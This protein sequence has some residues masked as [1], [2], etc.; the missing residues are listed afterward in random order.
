MRATQGTMKIPLARRFYDIRPSK[1]AWA[2][3]LGFAGVLFMCAAVSLVACVAVLPQS[4]RLPV[5]CSAVTLGVSG[6]VLCGMA[7]PVQRRPGDP[8]NTT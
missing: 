1:P 5:L 7:P 4:Q 6:I 3:R 2:V 8:P